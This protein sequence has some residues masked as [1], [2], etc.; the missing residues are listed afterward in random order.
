LTTVTIPDPAPDPFIFFASGSVTYDG[1]TFS[2][3]AALSNGY[4]YNVESGLTGVLSSQQQSVGD[5]NILITLPVAATFLSVNYGTFA[6]SSVTFTLS[7]GS[8]FTDPSTATGFGIYST[9]DL[10]TSSGDGAFTSVLLGEF[11]V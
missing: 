4:L 10:F 6:G 5:P 11:R 1:V 8:T 3:S 9:P 7:N 2:Q